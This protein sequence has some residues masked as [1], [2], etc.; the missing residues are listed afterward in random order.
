MGDDV[1]IRLHDFRKNQSPGGGFLFKIPNR[2]VHIWWWSDSLTPIHGHSARF[3]SFNS[4]L[5]FEL[6]TLKSQCSSGSCVEGS[7]TFYANNLWTIN[8]GWG[9]VDNNNDDDDDGDNDDVSNDK[10]IIGDSDN[11]GA[12]WT[13][14]ANQPTS[15]NEI[16]FLKL[17]SFPF[18]SFHWIQWSSF[19][20][21]FET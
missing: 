7:Q 11:D 4:C 8:C 6:Q 5:V 1:R 21:A 13:G 20:P 10:I 19:F 9:N 15:T 2:I 16:R 17:H 12:E 18:H 14:L 3:C